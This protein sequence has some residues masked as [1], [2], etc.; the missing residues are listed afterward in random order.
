M[1]Y[2]SV[3]QR[4]DRETQDL[5]LKLKKTSVKSISKN[6]KENPSLHSRMWR[7]EHTGTVLDYGKQ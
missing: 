3:Y 4:R 6:R 1:L 7:V 5:D 2:T